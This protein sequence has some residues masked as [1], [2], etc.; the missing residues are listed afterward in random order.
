MK[1]FSGTSNPQLAKKIAQKLKKPLGKLEIIRFADQEC[2]VRVLEKI[3]RT[4]EVI[5]IQSLSNPA[6]NFLMEMALIGD[7]LK[8]M[9]V[10]S[11]IAL[12]PYLGYSRQDRVHRPGEA[13][14]A[15]MV[16][17]I[18]QA[19]GY[20]SLITIDLHSEAVMGFYDIPVTNLFG[21][22]LF[23]KN[24]PKGNLVIVSPDAGGMKR[25]Q[26]FAHQLDVPLCFIEKKRDLAK[27][28]QTE[29]VR[30]VGDVKGKTAVIVDD[31]ITSGGTLVKASYLLKQ[32]GAKNVCALVTHADFVATTPT[33]LK[34]APLERVYTTDTIPIPD[35]WRLS[36]LSITSVAPLLANAIK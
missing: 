36:K 24:L 2:R 17:K 1:I 16:A 5:V 27:M 30:V 21:L 23:K 35:D 33:I 28:H 13:I 10:K 8:Q 31:I 9:G 4:E 14:S 26:K 34:E 19:A 18:I 25:A 6:D 29:V 11:I 32:E 3:K 7:A 15:R 12:V 22:T 20:T